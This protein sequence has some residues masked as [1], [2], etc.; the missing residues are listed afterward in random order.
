[1]AGYPIEGDDTNEGST[2]NDRGAEVEERGSPPLRNEDRVALTPGWVNSSPVS[3]C[4][5]H[6]SDDIIPAQDLQ[7]RAV[8]FHGRH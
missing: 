8:R 3:R 2:T 7:A 1:M 6:A 4:E 5:A